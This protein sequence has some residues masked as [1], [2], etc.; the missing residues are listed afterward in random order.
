MTLYALRVCASGEVGGSE[1][2]GALATAGRH[3]AIY[4]CPG[5]R[6][7]DY[8]ARSRAERQLCGIPMNAHQ[9]IIYHLS[10][11]IY[12]SIH[13]YIYQNLSIHPSIYW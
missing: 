12:L 4:A 8:C 3:T 11:R 2:K 7:R 1:W 5:Q 13:L 10:I 6:A 9:S